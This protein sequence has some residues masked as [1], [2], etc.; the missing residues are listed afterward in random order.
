MGIDAEFKTLVLQCTYIGQQLI[1]EVGSGR[2]RNGVQQV[3]R[4]TE[5]IV[6]CTRDASI[7][8][9]IIDTYVP[10]SGFFPLQVLVVRLRSNQR[11]FGVTEIIVGTCLGVHIAGHIRIVSVTQVLLSGHTIA[12]TQL[13]VRDSVHILQE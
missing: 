13:Q 9:T 7:Q 6:D 12:Q 2:S 11:V 4:F 1:A 8:E 10:G 5:V 3:L